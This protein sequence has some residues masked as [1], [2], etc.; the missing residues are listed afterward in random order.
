[1]ASSDVKPLLALKTPVPADIDIAQSITPL[2][3]SAVAEK[4]GILPEELDLYGASK[5][6]VGALRQ[7]GAPRTLCASAALHRQQPGA[8]N[9]PNASL[10]CPPQV[11]L[12]V[13]D[14]LKD[15]PSGKYGAWQHGASSA[16]PL[17]AAAPP[18]DQLARARP[19]CVT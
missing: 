15:A 10:A 17:S 19:P 14:R 3:I 18:S 4:L 6:K 2:H 16:T 11:Q 7:A 1:M 13:R 12:S 5:A 9:G 8:A